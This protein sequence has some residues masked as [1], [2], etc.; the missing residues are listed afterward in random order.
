MAVDTKHL[1][2]DDHYQRAVKVVVVDVAGF[3]ILEPEWV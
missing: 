1:G 2:Q 3:Q